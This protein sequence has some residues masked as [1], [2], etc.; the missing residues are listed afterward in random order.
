MLM[1]GGRILTSSHGESLK[2][3]RGMLICWLRL[4]VVDGEMLSN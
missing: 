3:G 1:W 2:W 4:E